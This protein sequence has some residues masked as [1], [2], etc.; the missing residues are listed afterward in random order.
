MIWDRK[1][2]MRLKKKDFCFKAQKSNTAEKMRTS[3]EVHAM[4]ALGQ[5]IRVVWKVKGW[6]KTWPSLYPHHLPE[7]GSAMPLSCAAE[8]V[9]LSSVMNVP[10]WEKDNTW[11]Q[12]CETLLQSLEKKMYELVLGI[13]E[14]T[15]RNFD[16]VDN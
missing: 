10:R 8:N 16:Y 13:V 1:Y 7:V 6:D 11:S 14:L 2:D 5:S 12:L 9:H 15:A 4:H 3:P